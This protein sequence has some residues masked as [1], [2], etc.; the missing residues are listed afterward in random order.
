VI[1]VVCGEPEMTASWQSRLA[2]FLLTK[3]L[4]GR[5]K[6]SARASVTIATTPFL[7]D[8]LAGRATFLNV[9]TNPAASQL[10]ERGLSGGEHLFP[11]ARQEP[12]WVAVGAQPLG[13]AVRHMQARVSPNAR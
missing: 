6:L 12:S 4:L 9:I 10:S 2:P 7:A 13:V 11:R 3:L 8:V 5:L 1:V